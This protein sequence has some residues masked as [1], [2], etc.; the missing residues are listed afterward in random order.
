[1]E[2][3]HVCCVPVSPWRIEPAHRTEMVTQQLFGETCTII[4]QAEDHWVKAKCSYDAYEGWCQKS[5]L[6]QVS[7]PLD[8]TI[9]DLSA[10]YLSKV[11]F[12]GVSMFIPMGCSLQAFEDGKA[13]WEDNLVNFQGKKFTP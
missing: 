9:N 1:M 3:I 11:E 4:D 5:H 2:R 13:K 12:N 8:F 6:C 10:D 7:H